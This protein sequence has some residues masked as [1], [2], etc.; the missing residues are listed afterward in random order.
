MQPQAEQ[1]QARSTKQGKPARFAVRPGERGRSQHNEATEGVEARA[2][3]RA[4][5]GQAGTEE[6]LRSEPLADVA[7]MQAQ[8]ELQVATL[9]CESKHW[10]TSVFHAHQ[11]AEQTI[12]AVLLRTRAPLRLVAGGAF[13]RARETFAHLRA[14]RV[15]GVLS[16]Q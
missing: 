5:H 16:Q 6:E 12:K 1:P 13:G 4:E 8:Q 3:D 10:S 15:K 14:G 9:L 7:W 11:A 2:A